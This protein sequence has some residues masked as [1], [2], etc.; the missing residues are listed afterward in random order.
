MSQIHPSPAP[1]FAEWFQKNSDYVVR[2]VPRWSVANAI[3]AALARTTCE[4]N[5]Y[6]DTEQ[7]IATAPDEKFTANI[8]PAFNREQAIETAYRLLEAK[9]AHKGADIEHLSMEIIEASEFNMVRGFSTTGKN[10]RIKAQ[11]K[12]GLIHGYEKIVRGL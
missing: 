7:Q 6:A 9:A 5:L 4:V 1:C 2:A 3:G 8:S 11:V 12:P 10:I